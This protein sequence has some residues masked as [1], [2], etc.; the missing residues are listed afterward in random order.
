MQ[1]A[2]KRTG[3]LVGLARLV[4]CA[5][6]ILSCGPGPGQ[7]LA[8]AIE[9]GDTA[10][11]VS[12]LKEG[13]PIDQKLPGSNTLLMAASAKGQLEVVRALL[14]RRWL[15]LPRGVMETWC[16]FCWM[17]VPRSSA[18]MSKARPR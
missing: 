15:W 17:A 11:A 1:R 3:V 2:G 6:F 9:N 18:L 12:L 16:R 8:T 10:A 4:V 7:Q 14:E 13:A 5:A